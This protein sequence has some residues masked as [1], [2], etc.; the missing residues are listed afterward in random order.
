MSQTVALVFLSEYWSNRAIIEVWTMFCVFLV[1]YSV[2]AMIISRNLAWLAGVFVGLLFGTWFWIVVFAVSPAWTL[3]LTFVTIVVGVL[4]GIALTKWG[5]KRSVKN[6]NV[7]QPQRDFF[8]NRPD[9]QK[10]QKDAAEAAKRK[11]EEEARN[12]Q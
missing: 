2:V 8:G 6:G 3:F 7:P 5:Q 11:R 1:T 12:N 9:L 4:A 10:Q